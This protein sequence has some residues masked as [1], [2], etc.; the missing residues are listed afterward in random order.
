MVSVAIGH[1]RGVLFSP[2]HFLAAEVG[3]V[4]RHERDRWLNT[5]AVTRARYLRKYATRHLLIGRAGF[6]WGHELDHEVQL[7]L[8]AESGLRGYP[9]RQFAGT[10]SLLLSAEERWFIADDL[11]QII[12][13]GAAAFGDSGFAWPE[14]EA[15][16]LADLKTAV[17]VSLLL[18][19][20]RLLLTGGGV[21]LDLAYA[22]TPVPGVKRWVFSFGAD[23]EF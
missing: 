21:R 18:G 8:G 23:I 9:V 2:D 5:L 19:S 1:T 14:P 16:S 6:L 7:L 11:G 3:V 17:G 10:R 15:L 20:Y 13:L 12:S 22:I 4:G